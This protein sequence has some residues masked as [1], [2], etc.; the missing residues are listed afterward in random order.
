[1]AQLV[2]VVI[3]CYN[4]DRWIGKAIQSCLDQSYRPIEVVVID[5]G[6]DDNSLPIIKE[7]VGSHPDVIRWTTQ[8]NQGAPAARNRGLTLANG[9]FIF[10]LD[11]DDYLHE[12]AI[13]HLV[14][15]LQNETDF[16]YGNLSLVDAEEKVIGVREQSPVSEDW[17]VAM[18][19]KAP[20]TSSVLLRRKITDACKWNTTLPCAQEFAFFVDVALKGFRAGYLPLVVTSHRCHSSPSRITTN[21]H[22]KLADVLASLFLGF[23]QRLI[24]SGEYYQNRRVSIN[25]AFL[26][27]ALSLRRNRDPS[28][29]K[30]LYAK[31]DK[32]LLPK[33]LGF[34]YLSYDGLTWIANLEVSYAIWKGRNWLAAL[35][36]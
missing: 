34:R 6:S 15:A 5:D 33:S 12:R 29:A 13:E 10:F 1:M 30:K 24:G 4:A 7:N 23:E 21:T 11:A 22:D 14:G 31:V 16:I 19:E 35:F 17:V 3:P 36:H 18:M 9:E 32:A 2:S 20:I 25:A 8:P 26:H 28:S 27:M